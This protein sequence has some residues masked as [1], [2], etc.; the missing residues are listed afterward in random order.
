MF[1]YVCVYGSGAALGK[2]PDELKTVNW[3]QIQPNSYNI[4]QLSSNNNH[5]D[6]NTTNLL[7]V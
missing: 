5:S 1:V 3:T 2:L 7:Q 6:H 4:S